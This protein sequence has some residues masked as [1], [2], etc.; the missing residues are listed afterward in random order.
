[1]DKIYYVYVYLDPTN[2]EV[3][4]VGK[5]KEN[6]FMVHLRPSKLRENSEKSKKIKKILKAGVDPIIVI[7]FD[8]LTESEALD[9]ER[10]II[11]QYGKENLT[12]KTLGG[13][14]VSGLISP[15]LGR[16][17]TQKAKEKI[18]K[19]KIGIKNPMFGKKRSKESIDKTRKKIS[20]ENHPLY[21]KCRPKNVR[22]KISR[23]LREHEWSDE[24]KKKRSMGM[25]K[26]WKKRKCGLAPQ[27]KQRKRMITYA[28]VSKPLDRWSLDVGI[29][30]S[31]IVARLRRGWSVAEALG[32]MVRNTTRRKIKK[33]L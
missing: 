20:G 4:Y 16:K 21:G 24:D 17:H 25:R 13:Q 6:R 3:F 18:R 23:S 15:F 2:D 1:M 32:F 30:K 26:V 9:K 27:R 11:S 7:I 5:G 28:G 12:N 10:E 33:A 8:G 31:T 14:G 19:S 22:D 29:K